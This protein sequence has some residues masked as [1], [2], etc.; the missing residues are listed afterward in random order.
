[1]PA[2]PRP[3]LFPQRNGL[4]LQTGNKMA[5][6]GPSTR[7][8]SAAATAAL[9]RR[10]RR[11]RCDEM[12]AAKTGLPGPASSPTLLVLPPPPRPEESGCAGCL[13][14]PGEAAALQCGHSR[15]REFIFRAPIK[16]SKPGELREEYECL[17]KLR[18]E[19]LQEEKTCE[20]KIHK[21]LQEDSEMGK[22]KTDEQKTRD[23]PVVLKTSLEQCP[24]RLSDSE[25]EEPS[26][27]QMI[28]T[29]RSA[30]VSKNSSYSLA[31][32]AGK[33]NT[34]VQRSQSCSDTVQDRV[35]S[36][37]RT[38]PP[39]RA[40]VTTITPGSTPIIGVL[41]STQNN[42]CLSAPDLTIEKRMPFS[43]L[44]SLTSLHKPERSI[45]PESNDSISE[46]LNHFKPIVCSPCTPP[47]RL[48]DGR[49]LSPLII[50]STP[51]NLNRSLQKQTSYEASPRILKK[52][53]QIFQERQIKKTL[54]KATLTS[55]APEGWEE[56]PGSEAIHSSKE[57]PPLALSTKLSRAQVL[58]ECAGPTSTTLEYSPSVNQTKAEQDCVRKRSHEVPVESCHSSEYRVVASGPSL[59]GE[60]SEES[61]STL[62]ATLDKTCTSTVMKT[63][64][65]NSVLL[66]NDVLGG[67]LKTKKQLKTLGHFDLANGILVD[68][69][70]EE[71]IPSLRR[72]RKRRCKTK[73]LEQN[74]VKKLRPPSSDIGLAPKDPGLFEVGRKWQQEDAGPM[75]IQ[76]QRIF[77][78]ERRTVSRRKGN[79]DQYLLRSS[80]LAG[81]K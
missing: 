62:D 15:C 8:S 67:V 3:L 55:L 7:A 12:A 23:E 38:A 80:S 14:T 39:N 30:F 24:A 70:G 1:M 17:R 47:K 66:K 44:S 42:R 41:L 56:L 73:H 68:S 74:G 75:A 71:S 53:E 20:D 26:R 50:K 52:W 5:A 37:L 18:E 79:M 4:S 45:S 27:G 72:G 58:S 51:R 6:A 29:H 21:V 16:L 77:D 35:K 48:P 54:S 33:L 10:G 64:A 34:K 40:K 25:N 32:L 81:A 43:S 78:S 69:L 9:S 22:R 57:R 76:S 11:G 59:E 28:Q 49:V 13:E 36:R 60:Q 46:E 61:R 31:F 63:S 65:V 2:A 19:K